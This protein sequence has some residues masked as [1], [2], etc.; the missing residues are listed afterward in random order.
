MASDIRENQ[1]LG[2]GP[3]LDPE[4]IGI[5]L[6]GGIG[7]G[8]KPSTAANVPTTPAHVPAPKPP[9]PDSQ[10]ADPLTQQ[11]WH[12]GTA[13][14]ETTSYTETEARIIQALRELA[15]QRKPSDGTVLI[16]TLACGIYFNPILEI[17]SCAEYVLVEKPSVIDPKPWQSLHLYHNLL[18]R[19]LESLSNK[20]ESVFVGKRPQRRSGF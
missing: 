9:S 13:S 20:L 6:S 14:R 5:A 16:G 18:R 3:S 12:Y 2:R 15:E 4:T 19:G 11:F 1:T 10:A 17:Y 7:V 8:G